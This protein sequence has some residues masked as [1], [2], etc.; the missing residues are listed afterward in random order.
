MKHAG[1]ESLK[2]MQDVLQVL[3]GMPGLSE[4]R[5]GIFYTKAG[6]YLHFHEDRAGMFADV[7]L[8][9]KDFQ[10]FPVNTTDERK[11]LLAHV[12]KDRAG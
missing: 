4:R 1:E 3:R 9:G 8:C 7:K 2:T 5:A 12:A 11:V 10:R 6:A